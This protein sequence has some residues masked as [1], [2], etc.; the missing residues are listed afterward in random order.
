M[1][2]AEIPSDRRFDHITQAIIGLAHK[3]ANTLKPGFA[4]KCYR[5]ALAHELRKAGFK[6]V[7]EAPLNVWYDGIIVGEFFADLIVEDTVVVETKAAKGI[8]DGHV[9]QCI[10]YLTATRMPLGLVVN[11]GTSVNVRRIAGQT[12]SVQ[13]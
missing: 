11:F 8:S 4:E 5:N 1:S 12:L 10:N 2:N 3:V 7:V 13:A 6:V 9:A